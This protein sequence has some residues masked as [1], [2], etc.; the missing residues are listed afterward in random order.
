MQVH[1]LTVSRAVGL[2]L[3]FDDDEIQ[4]RRAAGSAEDAECGHCLEEHRADKGYHEGDEP[5]AEKKGGRR[6]SS[7]I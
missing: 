7:D 2:C 4:D 1:I 5:G 3:A 6:R